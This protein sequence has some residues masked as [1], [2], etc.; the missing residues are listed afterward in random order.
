VGFAD[1]RSIIGA[2]FPEKNKPLIS[3]MLNS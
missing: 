3:L 1:A 2:C